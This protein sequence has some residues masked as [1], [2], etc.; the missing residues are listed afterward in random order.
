[1]NKS[2]NISASLYFKYPKLATVR[3]MAPQERISAIDK[4]FQ[5]YL[6]KIK[7]KS[8]G[9]PFEFIGTKKRPLGIKIEANR[10]MLDTLSKLSFVNPSVVLT[11]QR[12]SLNMC[13]PNIISASR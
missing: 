7:K 8:V 10:Q 9:Y 5:G 12:K 3:N 1:V 11:G 2:K 4:K 13:S 6:E